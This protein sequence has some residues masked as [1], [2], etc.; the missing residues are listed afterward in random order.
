M[1]I[2]LDMARQLQRGP[3][4]PPE[5]RG[6]SRE[7]IIAELKKLDEKIRYP[8]GKIARARN[9]RIAPTTAA[10]PV[11]CPFHASASGKPSAAVELGDMPPYARAG[12]FHCWSCG[13]RGNWDKL[14]AGINAGSGC[15][16]FHKPERRLSTKAQLGRLAQSAE[17]AS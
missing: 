14:A 11:A 5:A 2:T 6:L 4:P 17:A 3:A 9:G 8:S 12:D 15:W 10:T 1:K 13:E 16:E 7:Q